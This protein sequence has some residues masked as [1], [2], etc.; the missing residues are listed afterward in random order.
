MNL[1]Q[2]MTALKELRHLAEKHGQ[3]RIPLP[4]AMAALGAG[5][6][7]T[8]YRRLA[9]MRDAGWL[10]VTDERENTLSLMSPAEHGA[11]IADELAELRRE[12][13]S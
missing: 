8:L 7:S 5:S 12:L 13:Q 2:W 3:D 4:L 11:L 6:R 10:V 9:D 1:T